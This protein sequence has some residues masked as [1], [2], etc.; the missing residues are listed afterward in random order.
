[1]R[2]LI[3]HPEDS[4]RRGPWTAEKWDLVLDLGKTSYLEVQNLQEI[5]GCRVLSLDNFRQGRA[6]LQLIK[7]ILSTGRERLVD[8]QGLDWWELTS[9]LLQTDLEYAIALQRVASELR[10]AHE[11]CAT[12]T[13]S[14]VN[15]LKE[16]LKR[17]VPGFGGVR[18]ANRIEHY[19]NV[20]KNTS[21]AQMLEITLDKYD[22]EYNLRRFFAR[23]AL[24]ATRPV[25]LVPT[26]YTN[27]SR[28]AAAY[29]RM[30][31][32]QDFLFVTT[33]RS[34]TQFKLSDNIRLVNLG[35]YKHASNSRQELTALLDSW[36]KLLAE[37]QKT[38]I[39]RIL[40]EAGSLKSFPSLLRQGVAVRN[41][42]REVLE[43]EPVSAVFCGDDSNRYTRIPVLLARQRGLPTIDFH[44]GALDGRFLFK[45][46][47]SDLY[48]AKNEM[49][50]DYLVRV[51]GLPAESIALGAP[52][53]R[54]A[55]GLARVTPLHSKI[56]FF[57]EP[58]ETAGARA[59]EIYRELL[60]RLAQLARRSG[61]ELVI[62][63]HPF[64]SLAQRQQLVNSILGF[65]ES[66]II[67]LIDGPLRP[68]LLANTW[69]G[70]TVESSTVLDCA[71]HG[72]PCFLCGWVSLSPYGYVQQYTRFRL[73]VLLET[74]DKIDTI[75][76]ILSQWRKG[77][78]PDLFHS[79]EPSLLRRYLSGMGT[80]EN[81]RE[82]TRPAMLAR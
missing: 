23:V 35:S 64:E 19:W 25:V 44:H 75:P 4:F 74:P 49:E 8:G 28:T 11:F 68:A 69:F 82:D 40:A 51:C 45:T 43:R 6:D 58:Y 52:I 17:D 48:L 70:V 81:A 76:Q 14:P 27:V 55:A 66:G 13:E 21:P 2:I 46:L 42:W 7:E 72:I 63:L 41:C 62:K 18:V 47:P 29:A 78:P 57:S 15:I 73:G 33:R 37:L 50:R 24:R 3:V 79:L 22:A 9:L 10:G 65:E 56:V 20:L 60:P 26:A 32:D 39:I 53:S 59:E 80:M 71:L 12:R 16:V 1:M 67:R 38:P 36:N 61:K 30:L 54:P 31:P 5:S 34:A 77:P